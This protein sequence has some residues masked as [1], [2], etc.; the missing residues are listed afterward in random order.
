MHEQSFMPLFGAFG[1]LAIMLLVGVVLR[2][3]V[4]FFQKFLFPAAI[5]G[6]L[7]GFILNSV[8]WCN[9]SYQTFTLFAIH[10]F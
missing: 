6:G 4:G 10:L 2:A 8:G 1:W 5:I 9:I 3:K 7:I